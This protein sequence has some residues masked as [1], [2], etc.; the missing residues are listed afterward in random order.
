VVVQQQIMLVMVALVLHQLYLVLLLH[1]L[2]A[3]VAQV[4]AEPL[5]VLAELA[6]AGLD[7]EQILQ[8]LLLQPLP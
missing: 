2:V 5:V 4:K 1:T 3:V 7:M 6:V 8:I